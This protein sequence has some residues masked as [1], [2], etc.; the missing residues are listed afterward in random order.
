MGNVNEEIRKLI[1]TLGLGDIVTCLPPQSVSNIA[2]LYSN[3][4]CSVIA[5]QEEGFGL[6]AL[7]SLASGC[8]LVSTPLPSVE[9]I[10]GEAA[11]FATGFSAEHIFYALKA[12]L[13]AS[14]EGL[15]RIKS[16]GVER[17]KNFTIEKAAEK[18]FAVY[19]Q[20][21]TSSA[22][23]SPDQLADDRA[24]QQSW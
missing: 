9:E 24:K 3:A 23:V 2:A 11:F 1:S 4:S 8:P 16:L 15:S 12:C 10:V 6:V 21:L 5:S 19:Q 7:E 20:L 22:V 14:P 13:Q 17:A 18:T